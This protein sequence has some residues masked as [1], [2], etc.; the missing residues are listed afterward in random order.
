M[1]IDR[2]AATARAQPMMAIVWIGTETKLKNVCMYV[3]NS[4]RWRHDQTAKVTAF[5]LDSIIHEYSFFFY[6]TF[7]SNFQ[8]LLFIT[9]YNFF[10]IQLITLKN[11]YHTNTPRVTSLAVAMGPPHSP[12]FI[13]LSN[14]H[15]FFWQF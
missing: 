6:T 14:L 12:T 13:V 3:S 10:K 1:K 15:I 5:W 8:M 4:S 7:T 2:Q 11:C 9:F